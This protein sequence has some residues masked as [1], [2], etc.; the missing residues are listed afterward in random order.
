MN[1][2]TT[3]LDRQLDLIKRAETQTEFILRHLCAGGSITLIEAGDPKW[4]AAH[5]FYGPP[6]RALSQRISE[7]RCAKHDLTHWPIKDRWDGA[8]KRYWLE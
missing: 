2:P 7:L 3:E 8:V 4:L 1:N 6:I 5:G